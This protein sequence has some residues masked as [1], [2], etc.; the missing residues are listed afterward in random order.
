MRS[1]KELMSHGGHIPQLGHPV[2][3]THTRPKGN[4][5]RGRTS[6]GMKKLTQEDLGTHWRR[7][8][9]LKAE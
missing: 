7:I 1:K 3:K 6:R 2:D 9:Q 4:E 5:I 8:E